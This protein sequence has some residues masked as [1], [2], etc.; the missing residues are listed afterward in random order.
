M[1]VNC[2]GTEVEEEARGQGVCA[3]MTLTY[4]LAVAEAITCQKGTI[5]NVAQVHNLQE[6]EAGAG[7]WCNEGKGWNMRG[8]GLIEG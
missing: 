6:L 7:L 4:T 5:P 8:R 3:E 2:E 1:S